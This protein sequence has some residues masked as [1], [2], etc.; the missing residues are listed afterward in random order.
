MRSALRALQDLREE[1]FSRRRGFVHFGE[2]GLIAFEPETYSGPGVVLRS[3]EVISA[4]ERIADL[5]LNSRRASVYYNDPP[6][7][8]RLR[9][10]RDAVSSLRDAAA[11]LL[12]DPSGR[13]VRAIRALTLQPGY[14]ERFGFEIMPLPLWPW[15]FVGVHMYWLTYLYGDKERIRGR[16]SEPLPIRFAPHQCWMPRAEFLSRFGAERSW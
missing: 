11:W 1:A 9:L 8:A 6:V 15:V 13:Q 10:V 4:G 3:G 2:S 12:D 14:L 7:K 5:H 16:R